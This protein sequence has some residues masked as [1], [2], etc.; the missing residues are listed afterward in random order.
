MTDRNGFSARV[1]YVV[2]V[3]QSGGSAGMQWQPYRNSQC[4]TIELNDGRR[5]SQD[6]DWW[7]VECGYARIW[8]PGC[9]FEIMLQRPVKCT[10]PSLVDE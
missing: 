2:L 1:I 3:R 8:F 4:T 5:S 9:E 6:Y 7:S 10:S